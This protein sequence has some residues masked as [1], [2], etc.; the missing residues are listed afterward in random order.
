MEIKITDSEPSQDKRE[1]ECT[2]PQPCSDS[3]V[4]S[5]LQDQLRLILSR[6]AGVGHLMIDKRLLYTNPPKFAVSATCRRDA[7][8][9]AKGASPFEISLVSIA[10]QGL[11]TSKSRYA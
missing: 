3:I 10:G 11:G 7:L 4:Y 9:R 6:P 1:N 2:L 8:D 5:S